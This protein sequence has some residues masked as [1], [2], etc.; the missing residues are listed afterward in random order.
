MQSVPYVALEVY[1]G[2]A[3]A[4][5]GGGK[6]GANAHPPLLASNVFLHT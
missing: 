6:G 5:P 2:A 4:D 3:V 1:Y